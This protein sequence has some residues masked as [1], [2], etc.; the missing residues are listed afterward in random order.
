VGT[1]IW[2]LFVCVNQGLL[3]LCRV[4]VRQAACYYH[5]DDPY[6]DDPYDSDATLLLYPHS[7]S[8]PPIPLVLFPLLFSLVLKKKYNNKK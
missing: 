6:D 7:R 5:D 3:F 4:R 1:I 8:C 2:G